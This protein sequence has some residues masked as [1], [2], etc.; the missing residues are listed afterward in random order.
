MIRRLVIIVC[1]L[2]AFESLLFAQTNPLARSVTIYRD[3]YGV[4]HVFGKTDASVVFGVAYAQAE[5]NFPQVE[6]GYIRALGRPAEV[7]GNKE[8]Q[9]DLL[10][11]AME[12]VRLAQ[13]SYKQTPVGLRALCDA[14]A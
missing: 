8:L 4:P 13:E 5:D 7:Y 3:S 12:T 6:D 1:T 10:N 11:R 9:A 2:M 14:Y